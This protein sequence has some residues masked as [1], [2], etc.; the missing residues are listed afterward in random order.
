M[1]KLPSFYVID[2]KKETTRNNLPFQNREIKNE[3]MKQNQKN[4]DPGIVRCQRN[5]FLKRSKIKMNIFLK[6]Y[7]ENQFDKKSIFGDDIRFNGI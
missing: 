5:I 2:L 3:K 1:V 7:C 4:R 6:L